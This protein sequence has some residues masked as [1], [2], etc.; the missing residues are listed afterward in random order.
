[1]SSVLNGWV[2]LNRVCDIVNLKLQEKNWK[3]EIIQQSGNMCMNIKIVAFSNYLAIGKVL[4]CD[5][6]LNMLFK[7]K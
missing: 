5:G 7:E 3:C 6:I 4:N 1:M 2:N